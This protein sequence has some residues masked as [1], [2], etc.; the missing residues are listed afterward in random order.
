MPG[1][2][3][4]RA[5]AKHMGPLRSS[6]RTHLG[7]N[8]DERRMAALQRGLAK[9]RHPLEAKE[10]ERNDSATSQERGEGQ[11]V[12]HSGRDATQRRIA[13]DADLGG[14]FWRDCRGS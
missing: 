10:R 1:L 3:S 5:R 9:V 8:R 4:G 13:C 6:V 7:K 14:R 12:A 2:E 11:Q